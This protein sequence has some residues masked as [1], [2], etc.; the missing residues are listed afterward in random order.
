MEV[1]INFASPPVNS[2]VAPALFTDSA[3]YPAGIFSV[4]LEKPLML[5]FLSDTATSK[6]SAALKA[7]IL[8]LAVMVASGSFGLEKACASVLAGVAAGSVV[9]VLPASV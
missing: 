3:L 1:Q 8:R 2:K 4:S 6:L 9:V 7:V 5:P